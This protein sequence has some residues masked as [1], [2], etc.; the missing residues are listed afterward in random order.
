MSLYSV[1]WGLYS[2]HLACMLLCVF[3]INSLLS[4]ILYRYAQ[5]SICTARGM[6]KKQAD[7]RTERAQSNMQA[8][9]ATHNMAWH[10]RSNALANGSKLFQG[11]HLSQLC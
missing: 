2:V 10:G 9:E 6:P 1:H 8:Q 4:I 3:K 5:V 7:K 11:L